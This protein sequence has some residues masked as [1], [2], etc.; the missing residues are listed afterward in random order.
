MK[1]IAYYF[2]YD[3]K[4][5]LNPFGY[6]DESVAF[7]RNWQKNPEKGTLKSIVNNDNRLV[8]IDTRAC[9]TEPH[10]VLSG[11]NREVYE[12]C[13]SM[14]SCNAVV[15]HLNSC[16]QKS[17]TKN[18]VR[19]YLDALI[20]NKLMVTDGKRYLS[21]AIRSQAHGLDRLPLNKNNDTRQR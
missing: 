14:R 2:D 5:E 19:N 18:Q 16:F 4:H 1:K 12:Y 21:L 3:F 13:D 9:A 20:S 15:N 6:A 11:M 10:F 8:L 7:V 17:Y